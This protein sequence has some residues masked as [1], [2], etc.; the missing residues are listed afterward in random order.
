MIDKSENALNIVISSLKEMATFRATRKIDNYI[1]SAQRIVVESQKYDA[2]FKDYYDNQVKDF[3]NKLPKKTINQEIN[4]TK[5]NLN[6]PVK[7]NGTEVESEKIPHNQEFIDLTENYHNSKSPDT[8]VNSKPP[9]H[10]STNPPNA[11]IA[12]APTVFSVPKTQPVPQH[13]PKSETIM[14]P[15][16]TLP[17]Q[18]NIVQKVID[19]LNKPN[20][21]N[22]QKFNT[23]IN[24][25]PYPENNYEYKS[26]KIYD[27][28]M[29]NPNLSLQ[30]SEN[31]ESGITDEP[32]VNV[33]NNKTAHYHFYKTLQNM[34][35]E[36][37]K[38]IN[39]FIKKYALKVMPK[40]LST[41]IK[42]L[43]MIKNK[44]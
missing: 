9:T 10:K 14:A 26:D 38:I 33:T 39:S 15:S 30:S 43:K 41:A 3:I 28:I 11:N 36:D 13:I 2:V 22:T 4:S 24:Q 5:E 29:S 34:A 25:I 16:Q 17:A 32:P 19:P 1:K 35:N 27:E 7:F 37:P 21:K 6:E 31:H 40:D 8:L 18:Q 12:L 42:L 44:V 23:F 20:I